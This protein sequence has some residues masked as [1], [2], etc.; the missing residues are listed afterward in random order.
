MQQRVAIAMAIACEPKLLIADEP[1]TALDSITQAQILDL[2]L[3]LQQRLKLSI[4]LISHDLGIVSNVCQH[5]AVMYAGRILEAGPTAELFNAP[6]HPYLSGL[7]LT[8]PQRGSIGGHMLGISGMPPEL[9]QLPSGCKFNPRC[10]IAIER[11]RTDDPPLASV[12]KNRY[13]ACWNAF[14]PAWHVGGA[15]ELKHD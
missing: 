2:L 13:C 14:T 11:C 8:A 10:P 3:E 15:Q 12:G 7:L 6:A 4:L 9:V 1:T 5:V